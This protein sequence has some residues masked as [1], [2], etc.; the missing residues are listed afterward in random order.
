MNINEQKLNNQ[1]KQSHSKKPGPLKQNFDYDAI[2]LGG[3]IFT[4]ILI[5]LILGK[6]LYNKI[7]AIKQVVLEAEKKQEN[8]KKK[9]E[10]NKIKTSR[11]LFSQ[12]KLNNKIEEL[13]NNKSICSSNNL[14]PLMNES[15]Q[16][17][18]TLCRSICERIQ[19]NI[20]IQLDSPQILEQCTEE[21]Q[22][23]ENTSKNAHKNR[24]QSFNNKQS[25]LTKNNSEIKNFNIILN[26]AM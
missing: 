24:L 15:A 21:G 20:H 18:P 22:C 6:V 7:K 13:Q 14:F 1:Q 23:T 16:T 2:I 17:S 10:K 26:K 25:Q 19:E 9:Q 4:G 12:S 3:V 11:Q 8:Y 5:L